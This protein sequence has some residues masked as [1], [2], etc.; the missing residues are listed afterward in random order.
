MRSI[1][2]IW[3]YKTGGVISRALECPF[4]QAYVESKGEVLQQ[5]VQGTSRQIVA[6][7][8]LGTGI[9]I[10]G[11]IYI[12]YIRRLYRLTSFIQQSR[13]RGQNS[14][15]S[16]LIIITQVE[17]SQGQRQ[18]KIMS[19]YSVKQIDEDTIMEFYLGLRVLTLSIRSAYR[20]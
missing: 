18:S 17:N 6:I 2:Y 4:Y 16:K 19:K 1:I 20:Q 14:E 12:V 8:A 11:I 3:S 9:N 7:G 15:V 10:E 13:Y 5:Q